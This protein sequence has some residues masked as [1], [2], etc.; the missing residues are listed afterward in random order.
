MFRANWIRCLFLSTLTLA[1]AFPAWSTDKGGG[2]VMP[3]TATPAGY[4][5]EDMAEEL[6]YFDTSYNDPGLYPDTPFQILYTGGPT[7]TFTVNAGTRFFVP[8]FWI[9]D[10]FP[11]IGDFPD[12]EDDIPHY[13]FGREQLGAHH[14]QIVV[15]GKTTTLGADYAAGAHA[16]GLLDG[17]GSNIIQIGAFLTPLTKGTHTVIIRGTLDGEEMLEFN[18]GNPYVFEITYTVIVK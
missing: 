18:L 5:L 16:P 7:N 10:S 12:D 8:V 11:I 17:G 3:P 15:D 6:A 4:S 9:D 2:N 1:I 13:V 14:M